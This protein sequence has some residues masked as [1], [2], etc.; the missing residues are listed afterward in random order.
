[1]LAL[2]QSV[3][4]KTPFVVEGKIKDVQ[5]LLN[6]VPELEEVDGVY[7]LST[8]RFKVTGIDQRCRKYEYGEC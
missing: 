6:R 7:D 5:C 1:M 8:P 4:K 2:L 3:H